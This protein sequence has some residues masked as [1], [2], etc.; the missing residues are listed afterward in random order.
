M[1]ST[2]FLRFAQ[3]RRSS[4]GAMETMAYAYPFLDPRNR[5]G[6]LALARMVAPVH[7]DD[8]NIIALE[9]IG[10]WSEEFD[11][12]TALVWG[13]RDPILGR[14]L[15]R[16][17]AAFPQAK[18]T[19][20]DAGHFFPEEIPEVLARAIVEVANAER[21]GAPHTSPVHPPPA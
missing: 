16:H 20:T 5:A 1:Q 15:R 3:G 4:V 8:A 7:E 10:T 19:E 9:E 17:H 18:V 2:F 12:P 14:G 11:G 13:L 6:P 21:P